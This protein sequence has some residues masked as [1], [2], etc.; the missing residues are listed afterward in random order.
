MMFV[1]QD[2]CRR[3][4]LRVN[5]AVTRLA[6]I[7]HVKATCSITCGFAK[8]W[9]DTSGDSLAWLGRHVLCVSDFTWAPK[10]ME[11]VLPTGAE[12]V[13][14]ARGQ[15]EVRRVKKRYFERVYSYVYAVTPNHAGRRAADGDVVRGV[16]LAAR[17]LRGAVRGDVGRGGGGGALRAARRVRWRHA[18]RRGDLGGGGDREVGGGR[19]RVHARRAAG[20]RPQEPR[21]R[22]DVR[23]AQLGHAVHG[24]RD[25]HEGRGRRLQGARRGAPGASRTRAA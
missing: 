21:R 17:A 5:R 16:L 3:E 1:A 12:I 10:Y 23:E 18:A 4:V 13:D 25:A 8:D 7:A 24:D 6:V 19:A 20:R 22:A 11:I 15:V 9:A 14:A 2:A